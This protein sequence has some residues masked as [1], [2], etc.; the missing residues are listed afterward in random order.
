MIIFDDKELMHARGCYST[1][2]AEHKDT[3]KRLQILTGS[4]SSISAQVLHGVQPRDES[5]PL[6]VSSHIGQARALLDDID[7]CV[8]RLA[9]LAK[10]RSELKP[11]AWGKR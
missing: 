6:D 2:N 8:M 5:E 9:E 11:I 3:M 10:Q 1:L 7:R 4:L